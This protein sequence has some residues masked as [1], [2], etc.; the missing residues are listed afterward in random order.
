MVLRAIDGERVSFERETASA[1]GQLLLRVEELEGRL[2]A[3]SLALLGAVSAIEVGGE[4][5]KVVL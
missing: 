1:I 5:G 3:L 2:E 4:T